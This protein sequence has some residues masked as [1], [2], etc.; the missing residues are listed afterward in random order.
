MSSTRREFIGSLAASGT[1]AM[2]AA[3][4]PPAGGQ[5]DQRRPNVLFAFS[6]QHRA[7]SM[8]GEPYNDAEAPNLARLAS[9][10]LS[11]RN[12]IS[13]YPVCSP[14]RGMLLS[15]RWPYQS[16]IVDNALPL[17]TSEFSLGEAFRRQGY[18]TGYVG[19]WHLD[20]RGSE[21]RGFRPEGEARH[22]FDEW[23]AWYNTNPH[24]DRSY[25]FDRMT[26]QRL[27]PKPEFP[28]WNSD[29][30]MLLPLVS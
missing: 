17:K 29:S 11:V 2:P 6:D 28:I 16:G 8:P 18:R 15:G 22:G 25:K 23:E 26:R 21:G 9:Q 3:Q 10:G 27:Q 13:N 19:K 1:G 20:A 4:R 14:Y 7:C 5:R 24:F 12:C 30:N